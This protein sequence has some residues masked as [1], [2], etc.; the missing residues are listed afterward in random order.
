[1]ANRLATRFSTYTRIAA[2]QTGDRGCLYAY[3]GAPMKQ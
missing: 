2:D 1:M 3:T